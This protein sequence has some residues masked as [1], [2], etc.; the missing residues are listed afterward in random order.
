MSATTD[1]EWQRTLTSALEWWQ[2]AGVDMLVDEEARDWLAKPVPRTT[3]A[4]PAAVAQ[5]AAEALPETLEAFLAWRMGNDAPEAGWLTPRIGPSGPDDA[6]YVVLTDLPEATDTERLMDGPEGRLLDRMLAA[7]GLSRDTVYLA[8]LA[9][10]RPLTGRI[11]PEDEAQLFGLARHHLTLLGPKR[12]LLLG[13]A[14]SRVL[15]GADGGADA[16]SLHDINLFG[17]DTRVVASPHPR[18][19]MERPAA[20]REAWKQLLLLSRGTE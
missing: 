12:L 1:Q 14:A 16:T 13:Q 8:P 4:A 3:T 15:P 5:P 20:K 9:F 10:A 17:A 19:L 7:I 2:D 18:L 11:P 6:E